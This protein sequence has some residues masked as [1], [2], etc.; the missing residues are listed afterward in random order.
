LTLCTA[1]S[2]DKTAKRNVSGFKSLQIG[3]VINAHPLMRGG[4]GVVIP[5]L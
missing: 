1:D 4:G 5:S 3:D 2:M